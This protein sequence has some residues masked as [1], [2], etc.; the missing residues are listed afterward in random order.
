MDIII[1][2]VDNNVAANW[3]EVLMRYPDWSIYQTQGWLEFIEQTQ[4]V[5]TLKLGIYANN[6]L[7]GLWPAAEFH[8]GPFRLLGSPMKGWTTPQMGPASKELNAID[9]LKAWRRF[10][11]QSGYHHAR[12][13]HPIFTADIA[14]QADLTTVEEGTFIC[15]IPTTE[16]GILAQFHKSCR[17]AT[18]RAFRH[19]VEVEN[20]SNPSF[21]DHF[22]YQLEDVFGKQGLK[23]TFPKS[24]VETLW[25]IMKPTGHLLTIWAKY[26]GKIIGTGFYLISNK[27]LYAYSSSSLRSYWKCYPNEPIRLLAMK[28]A[29]EKG[30]IVHD[31]NGRGSYK[32][33]FGAHLELRYRTLFFRNALLPIARRIYAWIFHL[34]Q[35]REGFGVVMPPRPALEVGYKFDS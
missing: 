19:G 5:T 7:C 15:P 2:P 18:R 32:A 34:R 29:A 25:R 30:C 27:T 9:L 23:P 22:Y 28:M 21:V 20:T 35:R 31:L 8:K 12:V 16:E 33:K 17:E 6:Q 11:Q 24:R 10:I 26:K 4:N 3:D 1:R 13:S 14:R